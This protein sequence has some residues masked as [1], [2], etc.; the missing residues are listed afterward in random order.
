MP[1]I[2][3]IAAGTKLQLGSALVSPTFA[4]VAEVETIGAISEVRP[5]INATPL[6]ASAVRYI[7]GLKD[8]QTFE[9]SLFLLTDDVTQ[10]LTSGLKK[11][12]NDN[13]ERPYRILP[14]GTAKGLEFRAIITKH[15]YG[16]FNV[17]DAMKRMVSFR[18]SSDVLEITNTNV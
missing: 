3:R 10:G 8:G 7:G 6:N 18:L 12:F 16:P 4:D 17:T 5:E 13:E 9:V 15:D 2:V 14:K 11:V 1:D